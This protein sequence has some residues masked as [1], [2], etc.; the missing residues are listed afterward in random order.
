MAEVVANSAN[1]L[2]SGPSGPA[3]GIVN[4][5]TGRPSSFVSFSGEH[6]LTM[7]AGVVKLDPWLSPFQDALKRRFN[8][9]KDWIKTINDTEG[10]IDKFSRVR[11][12]QSLRPAIYEYHDA[13]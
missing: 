1:S 2:V 5:G 10:G 11:S 4:D 8:K 13:D 7:R 9:A 12:T 3:D 6:R